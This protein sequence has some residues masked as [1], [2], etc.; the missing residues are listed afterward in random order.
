[1][2]RKDL[3][4]EFSVK[5]LEERVEFGLFPICGGGGGGGDDGG[6]GEPP[7]PPGPPTQPN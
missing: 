2:E 4:E 1:M 5:E 6:G 3:L 7:T